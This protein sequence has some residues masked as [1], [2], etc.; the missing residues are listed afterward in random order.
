MGD[1]IRGRKFPKG[2]A[3]VFPEDI[4]RI[5]RGTPKFEQRSPKLGK[6][7]VDWMLD[8]L[9]NLRTRVPGMLRICVLLLFCLFK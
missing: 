4:T 1:K 3:P 5:V 7:V 9:R 8:L 6:E 2:S